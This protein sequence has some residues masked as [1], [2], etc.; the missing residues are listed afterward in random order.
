MRWGGEYRR[1]QPLP[2]P[3]T[4]GDRMQ[5]LIELPCSPKNIKD[6]TLIERLLACLDEADCCA[7]TLA[8]RHKSDKTARLSRILHDAVQLASDLWPNE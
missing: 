7:Q 1:Y 8:I 3:L 6:H 4:T 5:H 2:P